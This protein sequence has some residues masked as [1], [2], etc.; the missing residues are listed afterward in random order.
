MLLFDCVN[1]DIT[2]H[3]PTGLDGF[4]FRF[5]PCEVVGERIF[6]RSVVL[7]CKETLVIVNL[8]LCG[9]NS[10]TEAILLSGIEEYSSVPADNI[11]LCATH[12]HSGPVSGVLCCFA[13][14]L[15]YFRDIA[16]KIGLAVKDSLQR[17]VPVDI[18]F[19]QKDGLNCHANRVGL[20]QLDNSVQ[21]LRFVNSDKDLARITSFACHP[22]VVRA[23]TL[24]GDFVSALNKEA[25]CPQLFFMAPS[26]DVKPSVE[27]EQTE[28]EK[29][30]TIS[31][32]VCQL[33][34]RESVERKQ[35]VSN[36][37][38][39]CAKFVIPLADCSTERLNAQ[40]AQLDNLPVTEDSTEQRFRLVKRNT[41]TR[42]LN[43]SPQQ[44]QIMECRVNAL[45]LVSPKPVLILFLP[46]EVFTV[47]G[48]RIRK[49]C[50][51]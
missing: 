4:G 44:R 37:I 8:D 42:L 51:E 43:T 38:Y 50:T 35:N 21:A 33:L 25:N 11:A 18:V 6:A 16:K 7:R 45:V 39:R 5:S 36:M 15:D 48:Q 13:P 27:G 32:Q 10:D 3:T 34:E 46:F 24:G 29:C 40:L 14:D 49:I 9:L 31:R 1:V 22:T 30:R 17:L 26:G 28:E 12:T 19:E 2:P 41:I 23:N 20:P 47:T